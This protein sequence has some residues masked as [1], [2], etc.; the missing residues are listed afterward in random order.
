MGDYGLGGMLP[1][2]WH[3]PVSGAASSPAWCAAWEQVDWDTLVAPRLTWLV[4]RT[5]WPLARL[6]SWWDWR[7]MSMWDSLR[8]R[9]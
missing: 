8:G 5:A 1:D 9:G 6:R 7:V 4:D 3:H 2:E